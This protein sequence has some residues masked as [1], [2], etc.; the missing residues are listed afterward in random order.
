MDDLRRQLDWVLTRMAALEAQLA[1]TRAQLAETRAVIIRRDARIAELESQVAELTVELQ[2]RKKGFRPK[3]QAI[4]RPKKEQDGRKVGERKHPGSQ[5]PEV[6]PSPTDVVHDLR[7][8]AC[9]HC[10]GTLE[11]TGEFDEHVIEEI[12]QPKVEVHRYRRHKQCCTCCQK[13]SQRPAPPEVAEAYVGPRAKLLTAY[14]RGQLGIS[15]GKTT[16]LLQELFGLKLSRA[17]ALGHVQWAGELFDPVVQRLFKLLRSEPVIHADE[18]GWRIHGKNVWMWC[19]C[20]PRLALFLVDEHRSAAVVHK[21]LGDS[22]TGVLV[23]DF[24]AAYHAIDCA[25]QKCLV[26]LLRELHTLRDEATAATRTAYLQPLMTLLQDALALGKSRATLAA[27]DFAA[28]RATLEQRLDGL[29]FTKPTDP[30]CARIN[31]R[32]VR[33][34]FELLHF[35]HSQGVPADNNAGERDIRSVAAARADGGVNRTSSGAKAFANIQSVLRT[36]QKH[37]RHFLNYGLSLLGLDDQTKPLPFALAVPTAHD[38][39]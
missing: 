32:L 38:T 14:C 26:H 30:N 4:S 18:T 36:C 7:A 5:R 1:E 15:L 37:G 16:D 27:S 2:R 39:T 31:K 12:P 34:R 23:T 9:P 25:K 17:G 20:N 21:A 13:V 3:A 11:D 24:Y 19:F 6:P 35:L 29:I 10:G 28:A 8:D 33:H 22:L